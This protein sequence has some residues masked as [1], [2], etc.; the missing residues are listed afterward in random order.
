MQPSAENRI[1][2]DLEMTGLDPEH[3]KIIEIATVITD[4][5]LNIIA[6]GPVLAIH[7]SDEILSKMDNWNTKTHTRSGLIDRVQASSI[8]ELEAEEVTLDFV[9]RYVPPQKSPMCGN[10]VCQDRRFLYQSMRIL[11]QYFHYRNLDVSVLS[12]LA[13]LWR[14]DLLMGFKKASKHTAYADIV[15]SIAELR[16]YRDH[17]LNREE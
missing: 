12:E 6:E 9:M 10:S 3:D 7:Q 15:E 16:Y 1:W 8:T 2:I 14:P 5:N 17:F 4:K 13:R 11:E